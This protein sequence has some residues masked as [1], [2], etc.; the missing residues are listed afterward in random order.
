MD[1][2]KRALRPTLLDVLSIFIAS[3]LGAVIVLVTFK[4]EFFAGF[5]AYSAAAAGVVF[6]IYLS[7]RL[8]SA[9]VAHVV[10]IFVVSLVCINVTFNATQ[11]LAGFIVR[12]MSGFMSKDVESFTNKYALPGSEGELLLWTVLTTFTLVLANRWGSEFFKGEGRRRKDARILEK[13][14]LVILWLTSF[15]VNVVLVLLLLV[16][17]FILMFIHED[18]AL[19]AAAGGPITIIGLLSTVKFTTIEKYLKREELIVSSTGMT[20][21]PVSQADYE[22]I[23]ARSQE[24]TRKR[25]TLELRSELT[26]IGLTVFGT[27]LWAYGSYLPILSWLSTTSRLTS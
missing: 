25:L 9:A 20:G 13:F 2:L 18:I 1:S 17:S 14:C 7:K 8:R 5:V 24:A 12:H 27:I 15:P 21:P 3:I 16:A 6:G 11:I 10:N 23:A 26:G 4:Y 19:F 22:I